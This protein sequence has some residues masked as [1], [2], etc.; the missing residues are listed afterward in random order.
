MNT[1]Q[2]HIKVP[3]SQMQFDKFER[4]EKP[5]KSDEMRKKGIPPRPMDEIIM[6]KEMM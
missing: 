4:F 2:L 5:D 3:T 6:E 1:V